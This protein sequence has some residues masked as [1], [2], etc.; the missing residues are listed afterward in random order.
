MQIHLRHHT[1]IHPT[2]RTKQVAGLF[3]L[4]PAA[5]SS[6][7]LHATLP[8]ADDPW[9]IGAIVGAS[10]TGKSSIAR[11][12][13][14]QLGDEVLLADAFDWPAEHAVVDG[15]DASLSTPT[16]AETLTAVGFS[17]PPAW[18]RPFATLSTGQQFRCN[19]A[20]AL[21]AGKPTVIF[22]EFTSVVD[23]QVA[24]FGSAAVARLLRKCSHI[25]ADD[26][27]AS[28][29]RFVAV[30][31][32]RDVLDWLQPDWVLDLD[33]GQLARGWLQPRSHNTETETTTE[34]EA[35]SEVR[36]EVRS[37]SESEAHRQLVRPRPAIA[38]EVRRCPRSLW[39]R[40]APHHYLASSLHHTARCYAAC[41]RDEPI[42]FL[43]T[44]AVLGQVGR[45]NVH[46]LVTLPDYQGLGVGRALLESVAQME[47]RQRH[48]GIVTSHPALIASLH[49]SPRWHCI[50]FTPCGRGHTGLRR[51]GSAGRTTAAFRFVPVGRASR[52]PSDERC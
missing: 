13:A 38:L 11:E 36:V 37:E 51:T 34:A 7:E 16:I 15:F 14:R 2:F 32:H 23:R 47:S 3:D 19:L 42:A 41:W 46:R 18:L 35:Q 8:A 9:Q 39:P 17:S 43:A 31:C 6:V 33:A 26:K 24:R 22:D 4:P 52:P 28:R 10:G 21:L 27:P 50:R 40:F 25:H 5:T 30:T 45:R 12:Y 29:P 49:R 1:A 48:I 44:L 20:R